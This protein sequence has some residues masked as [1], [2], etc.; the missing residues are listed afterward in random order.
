[1]KREFMPIWR[2]RDAHWRRLWLRMRRSKNGEEYISAISFTDAV[3]R[4]E[5][6]GL[7]CTEYDLYRWGWE[8]LPDIELAK[9][10]GFVKP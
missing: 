8:P 6:E 1:M 7:I 2:D 5:K 3:L 9:E 4:P 10:S